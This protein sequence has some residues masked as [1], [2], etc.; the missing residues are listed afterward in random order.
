MG[1]TGTEGV[2]RKCC[3]E[4][5]K[6]LRANQAALLTIVEVFIHDPLYRWTLS[7]VQAL[8]LQ[9]EDTEVEGNLDEVENLNGQ[10]PGTAPGHT[11]AER[12]LLRLKQKLQGYEYGET[13]AVQGQVNQII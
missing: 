7:P 13:L 1:I 3:E 2:F 9:R 5:M 11:D 4:T 12:T 10:L 8:R 6:V